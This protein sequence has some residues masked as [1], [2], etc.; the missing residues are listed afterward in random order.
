MQLCNATM[1]M[2]GTNRGRGLA[3]APVL[4][5]QAVAR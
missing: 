1:P 5:L 4:S 3:F 2:T